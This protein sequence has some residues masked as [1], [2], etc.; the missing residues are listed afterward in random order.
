VAGNGPVRL[1]PTTHHSY[2]MSIAKVKR[3]LGR[4]QLQTLTPMQIE[5]F[6]APLLA[7]GRRGASVRKKSWEGGLRAG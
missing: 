5:S 6:Y 7:T 3:V 4:H 2:A 1:R